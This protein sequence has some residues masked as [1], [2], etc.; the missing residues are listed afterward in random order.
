MAL[1]LTAAAIV[2]AARLQLSRWKRL[3][4]ITCLLIIIACKFTKLGWVVIVILTL[5]T[6]CGIRLSLPREQK[7]RRQVLFMAFLLFLLTTAANQSISFLPWTLIWM[8]IA[9]LTLLQLN[10]ENAAHFRGTT[11][12][13]PLRC[14]AVWIPVA[15]LI[16]GI[17]FLALPRPLVRWR[18]LPFGVNGFGG[19][20]PGLA[21]SLSLEN[22]GSIQG[23]SDVVARILPPSDISLSERKKMESRMALLTGFHMEYAKGGRWEQLTQTPVRWDIAFSNTWAEETNAIDYF[24]Y[25]TPTGLIPM[26]QGRIQIFPPVNMRI[27][28]GQGGVIRWSYPLARPTPFKLKLGTVKAETITERQIQA[29][30]LSTP[31]PAAVEALYWSLRVAPGEPS[32]TDLAKLLSQ[33]LQTFQYTLD[34]PSGGAK[35]PLGDFLTRTR[36]GHC[37]YFAH[38]LA[39][40]LR[41]RGIASRVVNGY[42]LGPW[43]QAGGYWLVTQNEA[44]SWVEYVNPDTNTWVSADPTPSAAAFY[45][46]WRVSE[47]FWHLIDSMRFR[48]DRYVVRFSGAE[49]QSGFAWVQTQTAKLRKQN[50]GDIVIRAALAVLA[51]L[52]LLIAAWKKRNKIKYLFNADI[53]PGMITALRPLVKSTRVQPLRGETLRN[54]IGR[55]RVRRPDREAHLTLLADLIESNIYGHADADIVNPI[56]QEAGEWR[57]TT[58]LIRNQD[59][60]RDNLV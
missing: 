45:R 52:L 33:D 32:A 25:P 40:A 58:Q 11:T 21:D 59:M 19:A 13:P 36:A 60:S 14:A 28:S 46:H 2:E 34:N 54:W 3:L 16:G 10:W 12:P 51:V 23:N 35:D 4:E 55:L 31:D 38:A 15:A 48:W 49:Q 53:P 22:I 30:E 42:R 5:F 7:Q 29:R 37:E 57:K 27:V 47:K 8:A 9:G 44:H 50:S 18:P 6:L 39:S 43:I 41:Y 56:K 20:T 26:P 17:L 1:P 24:V